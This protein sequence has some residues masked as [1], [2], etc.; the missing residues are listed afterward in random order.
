MSEITDTPNLNCNE[1]LR[2]SECRGVYCW[3]W[4][5]VK[6]GLQTMVMMTERVAGSVSNKTYLARFGVAPSRCYVAVCEAVSFITRPGLWIIENGYL[7]WE[8]VN[9]FSRGQVSSDTAFRVASF[10]TKVW[11]VHVYWSYPSSYPDTIA[12][13]ISLYNYHLTSYAQDTHIPLHLTVF[14]RTRFLLDTF[15]YP[16]NSHTVGNFVCVLLLCVALV[17]SMGSKGWFL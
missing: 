14:Q 8:I 9:H 7:I 16:I 15:W 4:V 17:Y 13:S 6:A 5:S 3:P 2:I 1:K 12:N 11:M 10:V